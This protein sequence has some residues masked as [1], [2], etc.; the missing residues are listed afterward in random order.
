M[1]GEMNSIRGRLILSLLG[2]VILLE[3]AAGA[4]LFAYVDETLEHS[5]DAAL[6]ANAGAIASTVH[7]EEDGQPH[8]ESGAKGLSESAHHDEPFYF[9]IWRSDGSSLARFGPTTS[10]ESLPRLSNPHRRFGDIIL[11]G[12]AEARAIEMTFSP[13]VD[14]DEDHLRSLAHSPPVETLTLIVAHDRRSI[15]QPLA[16]LLSGL[17]ITALVLTVGIIAIVSWGVR[18]GLRPLAHLA[19]Q[20]EQI[21]PTTL[22]LRCPVAGLPHEIRPIT[23]KVNNL[24]DRLEEAFVRERRFS[25]DVAHELRT[26]LAEL[27]SLCEV[28]LRWPDSSAAETVGES[29][30]IA[31]QME[32]TVS[33][34]LSLVRIQ[35]GVQ[36]PRIEEV[37]LIETI[38]EVWK[39]LEPAAEKKRLKVEH[40]LGW[41]IVLRTDRGIFTQALRNLLANAVEHTSPDGSVVIETLPTKKGATVR[42]RNTNVSLAAEDIAHLCEP[43]WRK[44]SAR[45]D[46]SSS[47]LGLTIVD[48]YCRAIGAH[49]ELKLVD[50]TWFEA[51]I[52]VDDAIVDS[53]VAEPGERG[54]F[55][56]IGTGAQKT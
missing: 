3:I 46:H 49:L 39:P 48:E 20:V 55:D 18:R 29:L 9:Q 36:A 31:K 2:G 43:F 25:A 45:T 4:G 7:V 28:S 27:R 35:A 47:G 11:P 16:I 17:L 13:K 56:Q 1:T 19:K 32:E 21:G 53:D 50:R 51:G 38:K 15:D 12:G 30:A 5:L 33:S 40:R 10:D 37:D 23:E 52:T 22:Q 6:L 41:S 14:E 34:L 44:D 8:L 42:I 24:L 26:P 54:R